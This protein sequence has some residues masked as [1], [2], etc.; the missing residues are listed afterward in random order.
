MMFKRAVL[1]P[2]FLNTMFWQYYEKNIL[3]YCSYITRLASGYGKQ[4]DIKESVINK[5]NDTVILAGYRQLAPGNKDAYYCSSSLGVW[6]PLLLRI[7]I[8]SL[9]LVWRKAWEMQDNGKIW[10]FHLRKNVLFHN[11]T[12]FSGF[13]DC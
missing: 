2:L 11:G 10:I 9:H 8:I 12:K 13:G 4:E 1:L 7:R 3:Y 6:E 5:D